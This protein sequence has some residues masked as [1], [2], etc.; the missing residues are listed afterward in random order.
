M[1][2]AYWDLR[3]LENSIQAENDLQ[4]HST[5]LTKYPQIHEQMKTTHEYISNLIGYNEGESI[6]E[7]TGDD[8]HEWLKQLGFSNYSIE[9]IWPEIIG[10]TSKS[11]KSKRD[12]QARVN[13]LKEFVTALALRPFGKDLG[14]DL[15]KM[16]IKSTR[17][18]ATFFTTLLRDPTLIKDLAYI[19]SSSAFI[20]NYVASRPELVDSLILKRESL[21]SLDMEDF[22]TNLVEKKKIQQIF[23]VINFLK[24]KN[25]QLLCT[26]NSQ[27]ADEICIELLQRLK[28][29][30]HCKSNLELLALGKW[31]GNELGIGSDLDLI[32]ISDSVNS[33]DDFKLA[34]RFLSRLSEQQKAGA[35]YSYD[36][37][38]RPSGNSGPI[39]VS[40]QKLI[41]YLQN[42]AQAWEKQ[43]FLRARSVFGSSNLTNLS[44][45]YIDNGLTKENEKELQ[46]I[47]DKLMTEKL[48]DGKIN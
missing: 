2:K 26:A 18:K 1:E 4:I 34:R 25:V 13:F 15:L 14:L 11:A 24:N 44:Y 33:E 20:G 30:M 3:N 42:S 48:P 12:E 7:I 28:N 47:L 39:L 21:D 5:D 19:F 10:L 43:S 23:T 45:H 27:I 22:L 40:V 31:G 46:N 37:R 8:G 32:F 16:F 36:L 41:D 35:L 38:L 6:L 29:E 17:A 9:E